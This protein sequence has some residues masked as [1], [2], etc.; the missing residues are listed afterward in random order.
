MKTDFTFVGITDSGAP[1]TYAY[2]KI[3]GLLASP[4]RV[5]RQSASAILEERLRESM[6]VLD[7]S[8]GTRALENRVNGGENGD[9][10]ISNTSLVERLRIG[11]L[12]ATTC[13]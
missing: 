1:H 13:M 11:T 4:G 10:G 5:L 2:L 3:P 7:G 9:I 6:V 12:G 8:P